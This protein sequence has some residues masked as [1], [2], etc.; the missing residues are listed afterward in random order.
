MDQIE[1]IQPN[2]FLTISLQARKTH[3]STMAGTCVLRFRF[4]STETGIN[5]CRARERASLASPKPTAPT[6]R[7]SGASAAP[8]REEVEEQKE[9]E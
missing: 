4:A 8:A 6:G 3:V 2:F 1:K 7:E 9:K 5:Q